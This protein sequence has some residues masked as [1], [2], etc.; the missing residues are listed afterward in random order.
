MTT[1]IYSRTLLT[2]GKMPT[3]T[4]IKVVAPVDLAG[5]A[6][7]ETVAI[8]GTLYVQPNGDQFFEAAENNPK[9]VSKK[10]GYKLVFSNGITKHYTTRRR[11]VFFTSFSIDMSDLIGSVLPREIVKFCAEACKKKTKYYVKE[12]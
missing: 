1:T 2:I 11:H 9:N 4:N 5:L 7:G 8:K 6:K 12:G 10:N 3:K